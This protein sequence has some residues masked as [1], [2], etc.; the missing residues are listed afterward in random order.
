MQPQPPCRCVGACRRPRTRNPDPGCVRQRLGWQRWRGGG[1]KGVLGGG[2]EPGVAY[3][4]LGAIAGCGMCTPYIGTCTYV[5]AL[6]LPSSRAAPQLR[7]LTPYTL[8]LCHRV[9]CWW[10]LIGCLNEPCRPSFSRTRRVSP[11]AALQLPLS[12][13]HSPAATGK[14][15][16]FDHVDSGCARLSRDEDLAVTVRRRLLRRHPKVR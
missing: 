5:K 15:L 3:V 12:S 8:R 1:L 9:R 4:C 16:A 10:P 7:T 14:R 6:S 13:C 2:S 11:A